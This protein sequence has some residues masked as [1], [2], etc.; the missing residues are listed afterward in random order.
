MGDCVQI[1]LDGVRMLEPGSGRSL[2]IYPLE[3][4]TRWAVK[5]PAVF[6]FWAKS[7]VDFE[8]RTVRLLSSAYTTT[9]ILDALTAACIQLC[10]MLGKDGQRA[11]GGGDAASPSKGGSE[12]PSGGSEQPRR[13]S[14]IADWVVSRSRAAAQEEKQH[15]VPDEAVVKCSSCASDFGTFNRRHHCRNCGDIFCDKCTRGRTPL[16]AELDALP[17]RVC[18]RCL[19]EVTQRLSNI[20]EGGGAAGLAKV[21]S[22][23]TH[24]DLAKKLR[25]EMEQNAARQTTSSGGSGGDSSLRSEGS[26]RTTVVTCGKCSTVSLVPEAAAAVCPACFATMDGGL[27]GSPA[28]VSDHRY[29]N[30]LG[31]LPPGPPHLWPASGGGGSTDPVMRNV[32][33]PTCTVHLQVQIPAHG[34]ETVECGVCQHPFL[35]TAEQEGKLWS[36]CETILTSYKL[37]SKARIECTRTQSHRLAESGS[38]KQGMASASELVLRISDGSVYERE[39]HISGRKVGLEGMAVLRAGHAAVQAPARASAKPDHKALFRTVIEVVAADGRRRGGGRGGPAPDARVLGAAEA[40][41]ALRR[42]ELQSPAVI[43]GLSGRPDDAM[44]MRVPVEAAS[45]KRLVQLVGSSKPAATYDIATQGAGPQYSMKQWARYMASPAPRKPLLALPALDVS[46][47][48]LASMVRAP[49]VVT[50]VDLQ[51]KV[52]PSK[53]PASSQILLAAYGEN[54]VFD[55]VIA[56]HGSSLWLHAVQGRAALVIAPPTAA[57]LHEFER[58]CFNK[59]ID[60]FLDMAVSCRKCELH[61]GDTLILYAG[62]WYLDF[63]R[64]QGRAAEDT[65]ISLSKR[66][67]EGVPFLLA[68]L[69]SWSKKVKAPEATWRGTADSG[70]MLAELGR[71]V[72]MIRPRGGNRAAE[73]QQSPNKIRITLQSP[74][75]DVAGGAKWTVKRTGDRLGSSDDDEYVPP[76]GSLSDN[77]ESDAFERGQDAAEVVEDDDLSA[78]D[79]GSRRHKKATSGPAH[80]SPKE[81]AGDCRGAPPVK[82]PPAPTGGVRARLLKKMGLD[83]RAGL[84]GPKVKPARPPELS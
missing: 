14:S 38:I 28:A 60:S 65:C 82:K 58:W 8:Q 32:A 55:F 10:E 24:E 13:A 73:S 64:G 2:R 16:T 70:A 9:A 71:R 11:G 40:A 83:P 34:T 29:G 19:A 37:L 54:C 22:Q 53:A 84:M 30:N 4:I 81:Q 12:G 1:G 3:T 67:R 42:D 36:G 79:R 44:G 77:D 33:C 7:A 35:R 48:A 75:R 63:L 59:K 39:E 27:H 50:D 49:D 43:R 45:S 80:K 47:T 21:S 25:D 51:A 61:A 15:W 62:R 66:E 5:E 74:V 41:S 76:P 52:W 6:T 68:L 20:Q 17:V 46:T 72:Q 26:G 56:P 78:E 31:Q 18:D 57:N 23:R 69:K